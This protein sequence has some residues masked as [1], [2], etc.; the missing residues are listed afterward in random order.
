MTQP[1]THATTLAYDDTQRL[2]GTT[3]PVGT[4]SFTRD[5]DGRVLTVV[6]GSKTLTRG[7]DALGRLTSYTDGDGNVIGY[8]Y[9]YIG[10]LTQLTLTITLSLAVVAVLVIAWQFKVQAI[11]AALIALAV[12]ILSDN[13]RELLR[14]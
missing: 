4:I 7:Y 9:D 13:V 2:S 1:S 12:V 10:R 14:R 6:E 5:A 8:A 11:L 3:D